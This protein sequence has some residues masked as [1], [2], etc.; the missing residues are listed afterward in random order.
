MGVIIKKYDVVIVG[1]GP[2]GLSCARHLSNSGLKVLVLEKN[3]IL[4]KKICSG[5]VSSKTFP[6][7]TFKNEQTWKTVVVGTHKGTV[8]VSYD[9]P[10][11]WTVG[12]FE[13][14]TFLKNN[15]DGVVHFSEPVV[16]IT[17]DYVVTSKAKYKYKYLVGADGS[18]SKVRE[19][20]KLPMKHVVGWAFHFLINKPSDRFAVYW[21]PKIF[22][23]GYGYVMSKNLN[24]TMIGGAIGEPDSMQKLAPRVKEWVVKEF[25]LDITKLKSEGMCGNADFRGWKFGN[26]FLV[27]DAAGLLNPVTTEGIYYAVKS[28]EGVAKFIL[29][30]PEGK[31]IMEKMTNTHKAQVLL[32]DIANIWPICWIVHW[33]LENPKGFLRSKIFNYVFWKFMDH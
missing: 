31:K 10:F 20:L 17:K 27:G 21:L 19:F 7:V 26:I 29:E 1:G 6:G 33:I 12:R 18:F 14:E 8:P 28:G 15:S 16:E 24:Q 30:N 2:G 3:N 32:F 22:P 23:R 9:R 5:E 25:N 13:L 11:L 4:G